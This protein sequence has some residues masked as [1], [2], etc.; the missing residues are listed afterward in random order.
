MF[1]NQREAEETVR[2]FVNAARGDLEVDSV[3][4]ARST[5][6]TEITLS[7]NKKDVTVSSRTGDVDLLGMI[8]AALPAPKKASGKKG[9]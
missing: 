8:A 5:T 7:V 9:A 2:T 6:E 1:K 3:Q 4:L